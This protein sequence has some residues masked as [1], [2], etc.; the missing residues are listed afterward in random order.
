MEDPLSVAAVVVDEDKIEDEDTCTLP[1]S[2]VAVVKDDKNDEEDTCKAFA[3]VAL[4]D[5]ISLVVPAAPASPVAL[6]A[7]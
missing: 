4:G 2:V 1:A 3:P 5:L 6:V 7:V